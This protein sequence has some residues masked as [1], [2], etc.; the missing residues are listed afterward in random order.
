VNPDD[1]AR[2]VCRR[3]ATLRR[4]ITSDVRQVRQSARQMTDWTFYVRRFP[5]ATAALAAAAGFLLVPRK[6]QVVTPTPEQLAALAKSR[7]FAK[8][9][10]SSL[11]P[12]ASMLGG[13]AA[14]LAAIA[15][16]AALNYVTEQIR[17]GAFA[18]SRER[19]EDAS[20]PQHESTAE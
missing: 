14:T 4:E 18:K 10:T 11:K 20:E 8:A 2:E 3:M 9:A 19:S 1:E 15:A 17:S 7:E 16:R 5:W 6:Q 13:I 12:P